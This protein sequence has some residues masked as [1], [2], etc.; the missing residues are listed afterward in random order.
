[1]GAKLHR[2]LQWHSAPVAGVYK[3]DLSIK[4]KLNLHAG[5]LRDQE[6]VN[7]FVSKNSVF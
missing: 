2:S 1:M 4:N 7:I 6:S 3:Y 5:F